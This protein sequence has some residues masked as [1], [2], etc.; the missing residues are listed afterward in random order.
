MQ[1]GSSS[2]RFIYFCLSGM[3]STVFSPTINSLL[4]L[5]TVPFQ[6]LLFPVFVLL[7]IYVVT[8][9]LHRSWKGSFYL[10]KRRVFMMMCF[11]YY[12]CI[13]IQY[14][15]FLVLGCYQLNILSSFRLN[16]VPCFILRHLEFTILIFLCLGSLS[17]AKHCSCLSSFSWAYAE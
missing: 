9:W 7:F 14:Y 4:F 16:D 12:L 3:S 1:S 17:C 8:Y 2:S 6:H 10:Q 11:T 15:H 5:L 13:W